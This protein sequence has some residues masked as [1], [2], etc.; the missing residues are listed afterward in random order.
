[1]RV[2]GNDNANRRNKKLTFNS[3]AP[4]RSCIAK[5]NSIFIDSAEDLDIIMPMYSDNCS[6]TSGNLC[7]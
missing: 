2:T 3:N 1:M 7:N 4:F 5:I 6:M